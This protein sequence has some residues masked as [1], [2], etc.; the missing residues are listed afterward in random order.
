MKTLISLTALSFVFSLNS[1]AADEPGH[2]LKTLNAEVAKEAVA[3]YSEGHYRFIQDGRLI[4]AQEVD[5]SRPSCVLESGKMNFNVQVSYRLE[6]S[7]SLDVEG[8]SGE[9][10]LNFETQSSN[11]DSY[12]QIYCFQSNPGANLETARE[13]LKSVFEIE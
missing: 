11:P 6:S 12:F 9:I 5:E 3:S 4:E 2:H 8:E 13:G 10:E 1:F 7:R